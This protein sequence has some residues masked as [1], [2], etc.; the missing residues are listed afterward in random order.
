MTFKF[1]NNDKLAFINKTNN[2][3]WRL[4]PWWT[5]TRSL[6]YDIIG[7]MHNESHNHKYDK[8]TETKN[9]LNY[10]T[11]VPDTKKTI[12]L[13]CKN[14]KTNESFM[15]EAHICTINY[16]INLH[17]Y[18]TLNKNYKDVTYT[19]Y[20]YNGSISDEH[21]FVVSDILK[22]YYYTNRDK[23]NY[24]F[25]AKINR[26]DVQ[27]MWNI[28]QKSINHSNREF[29]HIPLGYCLSDTPDIKSDIKLF[30]D[31]K[32]WR[33]K[34]YKHKWDPDHFLD[35]TMVMRLGNLINP[36]CVQNLLYIYHFGTSDVI[37]DVSDT[38]I[39]DEPK[40]LYQVIVEYESKNNNIANHVK[41]KI[42]K[43]LSTKQ[44][45]EIVK[46]PD[47]LLKI[48]AMTTYTKP[49]MLQRK[50]LKTSDNLYS[51]PLFAFRNIYIQDWIPNKSIELL[52]EIV[53]EKIN[54]QKNNKLKRKIRKQ[55]KYIDPNTDKQ[56]QC[57]I[58]E[59]DKPYYTKQKVDKERRK[60]KRNLRKEFVL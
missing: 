36:K 6:R 10:I 42:N 11:V 41:N 29:K 14:S 43:P 4:N 1:D 35:N 33:I 47:L 12:D 15:I 19:N 39:F 57:K 40:S 2:K 9:V 27:K 32:I 48:G 59:N 44:A 34:N 3:Y 52:H 20:Q 30:T 28:V 26:N 38:I 23:P 22:Y 18:A 58:D 49:I 45:E 50:L 7:F 16:N 37:E 31:V 53:L 24:G 25:P 8:D 60:E 54:Q 21:C 17:K 13:I 46:Y 5:I 56:I 51:Y 55:G